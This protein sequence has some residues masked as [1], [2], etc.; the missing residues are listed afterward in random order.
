MSD[1]S[2]TTHST[3]PKPLDSDKIGRKPNPNK[4]VI[5]VAGLD[6]EQNEDEVA[7]YLDSGATCH[8]FKNINLLT[9][10]QSSKCNIRGVSG[11][12]TNTNK[13]GDL[14]IKPLNIK[15]KS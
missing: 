3:M 1:R 4:D 14:V 5:M 11:T 8:I 6:D 9:N 2:E 13:I 12:V 7:F 10:I 15:N